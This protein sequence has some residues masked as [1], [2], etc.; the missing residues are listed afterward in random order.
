MDLVVECYLITTMLPKN[1]TYGLV[2]QMTQAAVSVPANIAEGH[3]RDHPGD[4]LHHLSVAN[5]SLMELE[6][7]LLLLPRLSYLKSSD[8]SGLSQEFEENNILKPHTSKLTPH[9]FWRNHAN[10]TSRLTLRPPH[11]C[12]ETCLHGC[13]G[14]DTR[15]RHRRQHCPVQHRELCLVEAAALQ[16]PRPARRRLGKRSRAWAK[17]KGLCELSRLPGVA[18]PQPQL[19]ATGSLH[20]GLVRGQTP[21]M[22]RHSAAGYCDSGNGRLV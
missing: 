18:S 11:A 3:G 6:T 13:C 9:P 8:L 14:S 19:R 15:T 17:L 12:K 5:S 7:H 1:E 22:A 21:D 2:N 20:L 4:H 10:L 16:R